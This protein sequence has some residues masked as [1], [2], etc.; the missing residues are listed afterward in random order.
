MDQGIGH[1]WLRSKV[2]PKLSEKVHN[3]PRKKF[4]YSGGVGKKL[5]K[6][7]LEILCTAAYEQLC[8]LVYKILIKMKWIMKMTYLLGKYT[9]SR[10]PL[11]LTQTT[12]LRNW[13]LNL[14]KVTLVHS[15]LF[16]FVLSILCSNIYWLSPSFYGMWRTL[17]SWHKTDRQLSGFVMHL[18]DMCS[19]L[20]Q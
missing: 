1:L 6:Q 7:I 10:T 19:W 12:C 11:N 5:E 9:D 16:L 15:V 4:Q 17:S 14:S 18:L 2:P 13:K 8:C 3:S 20:F